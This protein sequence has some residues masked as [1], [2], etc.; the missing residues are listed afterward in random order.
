VAHDF[1]NLLTVIQGNAEL[2]LD[3]PSHAETPTALR[4]ILT[5]AAR[6]RDIVKQI[7]TFSRPSRTQLVPVAMHGLISELLPMLRASIPASVRIE[8]REGAPDA[9]VEG[10]PTQLHQMLLNL[11]TNAEHAMRATGGG[12]LTIET[13]WADGDRP[14]LVIRVRDTGVGMP[15]EVQNRIF[16]PFYTTKPVGQGTGLGLSVLHG[17]VGAHGGTV[18]VDSAV[19]AG[20]VFEV[21]LPAMPL[22]ASGI[23]RTRQAEPVNAARL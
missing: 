22:D 5:A 23:A 18:R 4:Q 13:A 11:C 15:P 19:G 12:T 7:L 2:A 6:A 3:A 20:A 17:I 14:E 9:F 8:L 1:N 10:D 21:R 16:E